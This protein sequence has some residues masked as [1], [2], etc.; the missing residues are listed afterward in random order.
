MK[1]ISPALTALFLSLALLAP[2]NAAESVTLVPTDDIGAGGDG[3]SASLK[4]NSWNHSYLRFDLTGITHVSNATLRLYATSPTALTTQAWAA[5]GDNWSE[6]TGTPNAIAYPWFS[7]RALGAATHAQGY[8]DIDVTH[9]VDSEAKNDGIASFEITNNGFIWR[10]YGSRSSANPPQLVLTTETGLPP[11]ELPVAGFF[12]SPSTAVAPATIE[13]DASISIDPDGYITDYFW[14]IGEND[15]AEGVIVDHLF[16]QPGD[17]E[18]TLTVIDNRGDSTDFT[19]NILIE[20]PDTTDS[21]TIVLLPTDDAGPGGD[22][23]NPVL[24]ASKWDHSFLRFDVGEITQL[25]NARLRL[26]FDGFNSQTTR[27]WAADSDNW[28]EQGQLPVEIGFNWFGTE[29]VGQINHASGYF[30]MDVTSFVSGEVSGDGIV[31]F[32]LS[33]ESGTYQPYGSRQSS[34]PPQLIVLGTTGSDGSNVPPTAEIRS[35][36]SSGIAPLLVAFDGSFSTDSDGFVF[37]YDW[38]F[39]DGGSANSV[40]PLHTFNTPGTYT[41][42]MTALDNEGATATTTTVI[43]VFPPL[44][45]LEPTAAFTA[46]PTTGD[47]PLLVSLDASSSSDSD[48]TVDGYTWD[49]GN[50]AETLDALPSFTFE[51]PG[52]YP[53]TLIVTDDEGLSSTATSLTITV[54]DPDDGSNGEPV[55]EETEQSVYFVGNSVSDGVRYD[56]LKNIA[57]GAGKTHTWGRHMIPGA[58]LEWNWNHPDNAITNPPFGGYQP[59]LTQYAWKSLSLQPYDRSLSVDLDYGSRFMDLALAT[60]PDTQV[61]IFAFYPRLNQGD[62][63]GQWLADSSV[64]TSR[65]FFQSLADALTAAHPLAKPVKQFPVGEVL[66]RLKQQIDAGEIAGLNS[67]VDLYEDNVHLT[68]KGEFVV[69]MTVYATLYK[70][71]PTGLPFAAYTGVDA[72]LALTVQQQVWEV[73]QE[74]LAQ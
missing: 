21:G 6:S 73:V 32:E 57:E 62:W 36:I 65:A 56:T 5:S 1:L 9:F 58:P 14:Q 34:H 7:A 10:A 26:H 59:A 38:D 45:N 2:A 52:Q 8:L 50:G 35:D 11:N 15:T 55:V 3:A 4:T 69:T 71:D 49:F 44:G 23:E 29:I 51:Q 53:I 43:E 13:F 33:N 72:P 31:S 68:P 67:I 27:V 42:T 39:A 64:N 22:G 61:Y 54:N 19:A 63:E 16:S 12:S 60:N 24:H 40:N 28:D 46:T 37:G 66:Y 47:A 41:V 20:A 25:T 48:G 70:A 30:E 18:V 17:Y 74:Y